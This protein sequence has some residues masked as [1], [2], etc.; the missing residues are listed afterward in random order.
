MILSRDLLRSSHFDT[1]HWASFCDVTL[2]FKQ[3][4]QAGNG[5]WIR[6]DEQQCRRAFRF[7]LKLLNHAVF[8]AAA[9]RGKKLRVIPVIERQA[10]GRWHYHAAIEVP[11][12]ISALRFDE[13]ARECWSKVDWGRERV[14]IKDNADQGWIDYMLKPRQ[15]SGLED[16]SDCIDWV[17]LHNPIVD[18]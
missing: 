5:T 18:A 12:H 17:S 2:T 15:K 9:R 7:F 3:A 16:W 8:G 1:T 13:I 14:E 6:L 10:D 4:R 11:P